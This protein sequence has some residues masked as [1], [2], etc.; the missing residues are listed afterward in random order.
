MSDWQTIETAPHNKWV[1]LYL[2]WINEVRQGRYSEG[3]WPHGW[4]A[5]FASG[6]TA[7]LLYGQPTHWMP[8][9]DPPPTAE[10]P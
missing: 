7:A 3:R 1:L 8:L 9:P 4:R 6:Q 2:P 5:C 10:R